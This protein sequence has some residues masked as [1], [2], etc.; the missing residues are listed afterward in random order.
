MHYHFRSAEAF[1]AMAAQGELL[2]WAQVFGRGYGTPR[3]PVE[4]ALAR[5]Q[6][7]LF[8]IDWQGYRQLRAALPGD[9][10]GLFVLPPSLAELEARLRAR[11]ARQRG[12]DRPP[13]GRRA[14]RDEPRAGIRPRAGEPRFRPLGRGRA[15]GAG[16]GAA[17]DAP[18]HRASPPS[19]PSCG[20]A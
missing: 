11:G 19:W 15:R 16:G 17:G 10:V 12:G 8:D 2:E 6:D 13:H 18:A 20:R 3:A 4:A 14:R 7:M 9:V 1:A 5:G